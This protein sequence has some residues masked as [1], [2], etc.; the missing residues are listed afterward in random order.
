M[1]RVYTCPKGHQ[2]QATDTDPSAVP[3]T[4]VS[5]PSCGQAG[6]AADAAPSS[7]SGGDTD[8]FATKPPPPAPAADEWQTRPPVIDSWATRPGDAA[9]GT[10]QSGLPAVPGY[11]ILGVLG[12]GGMG[13]VLRVRDPKFDRPLA[14]KVLLEQ[15]AGDAGLAARFL[16]EARLTARLQHPGVA[17]VQDMGTLADGRPFFTMKLVQGHTLADLLAARKDPTDDLPRFLAVFAQVCQTVA[18]AHARGVIHR[19]LKPANVMVGEFGEVQ[20]M[21][22]GL[23]KSLQQRAAGAEPVENFRSLQSDGLGHQT[24]V[25]DVVGTPQYM[26]PEQAQG[27]VDLLDE[28]CDVFGLGAILCVILTN[29]PP[30]QGKTSR[31][32]LQQA[33]RAEQTDIRARLAAC[34]ADAELVDL[35]RACLAPEMTKR[36]RDGGAVAKAVSAYQAGVQE[37]LR[38]AELGKAAAQAKAQEE[39]KRRKVLVGLAAAILAAVVFAGGGGWYYQQQRAE[40]RHGV[41]AGLKRAGELQEKE[42]WKEARAVLLEAEDRL[43]ATGPADLRRRVTQ[44]Q[45]DLDIVDRLD[46]I[47]LRMATIVEGKMDYAGADRDYGLL[48]QEIG[49]GAAGEDPREVA[50]RVQKSSVRPRLVVAFDVWAAATDDGPRRDWVLAVVREADPDPMRDRLRSPA[51]WDKRAELAQV[52][53]DAKSANLSPEMSWVLGELLRLRGMRE[54]AVELLAA[55]RA[56]H[57]GDFWLNVALA[58]A[59]GEKSEER[60]GY[61][62]A[63]VALRPEAAAVRYNLGAVLHDKNLLK[64]AIAEYRKGIDLDPQLAPLHNGLGLALRNKGRPG[65]AIAE[66][67]MAIELDPKDAIPHN[68]LGLALYD[69]GLADEAIAEYRKAIQLDRKHPGLHCNLGGALRGKG[70][71]DEA[72]AEFRKAI[73]LNPKHPD[74]HNGLGNALRDQGHPDEAIAEYR[75]AIEL[76]PKYGPPHCGLGNALLDKRR[77]DDAIVEYRKAIELDPRDAFPH[78]GLGNALGAKGRPDEAIAE[79]RKAVE[80]D[81]KDAF[82]HNNLGNLLL[83]MGRAD[84]ALAEF[85]KAMELNPMIADVH[86]GLGNAL[87]AKG[88]PDE[89]IAEYRKAIELDPKSAMG[90]CNLG[91]ALRLM[92]RLTESLDAYRKGHQLGSAQPDWPY[93]S[94]QWV[95]AV[96]HLVEMDRKLAAILA[97][98]EKPADDAERLALAELCQQ[99]F[100]Q[101]NA[102]AA[103]LYAEAFANDAKL[104][105]DLT[106]PY[107][108]NAACVAALAGCGQG[109]DVDKLDAKERARLRQQAAMWL[110]ADLAHWTKQAASDK[111][112]ER[113]AAQETLKH[114]QEDTDLAGVRDKDALEK[115][116]ADERD[117]WRKLWQDVAELLKKAGDAK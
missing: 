107:R 100:K 106:K 103:R 39:R 36:L 93:P 75:K 16:E 64:E 21:D 57:A 99:P 61:F 2:W 11:D 14:V 90:H 55:A 104:A 22:W 53:A 23:A 68:N 111:P 74:A 110:R 92:G 76:N 94:G 44:A 7:L 114:W 1:P 98:K 96:E 78:N 89:A 62:M 17:P 45:A 71:T 60:I 40:L 5:C 116:P 18:Y 88:R 72:I 47:R 43:D 6:H 4:D 84:E 97:G 65:E 48:F 63:A 3:D 26:A 8:S 67:R 28:R 59:L 87:G 58:N 15:H 29:C 85:R 91:N 101:M 73:E 79:Y 108:Y 46:A 112:K 54:D 20:V 52:A 81:S 37:R 56:A 82:P 117:A 42:K 51:V 27:D 9:N 105:D 83:E 86:N 13:M 25:G 109:K 66:F 12:K 70:R 102:A 10:P 50:A 19:D 35:A 49:I 31:E 80:L 32:V 69:M 113:A 34:K 41:E 33:A 77:S 30:Y 115:L 95:R 24:E 38:T